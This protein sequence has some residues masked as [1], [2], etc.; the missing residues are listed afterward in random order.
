MAMA[1]MTLEYPAELPLLLKT[2]RSAFEAELRFLAAAK[3]Y[4]L[5]RI[6]SGKAARMLGM[7]RAEFLTRLG[8]YGIPAVNLAGD[9]IQAEVDAALGQA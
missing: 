5:G 7:P 4:E 6:S 2:S 3:L 8:Q 1:Q 9:E